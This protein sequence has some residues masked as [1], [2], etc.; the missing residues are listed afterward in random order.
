MPRTSKEI[1]RMKIELVASQLFSQRN[2]NDVTV[3]EIAAAA[4]ITRRTL[5]QHFP[6][7]LTLF[8]SIYEKY[9]KDLFDDLAMVYTQEKSV[10]EIMKDLLVTLFKFSTEHPNFMKKFWMLDTDDPSEELPK[11][12]LQH[13][14]IW[15]RA[16]VDLGVDFYTKNKSQLGLF[17][18][19][20]AELLVHYI[21]GINKGIF[22]QTEKERTLNMDVNNNQLLHIFLEQ[23][24]L[25]FDSI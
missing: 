6:S 23:I 12:V 16:C 21:S 10:K 4:D 9:L 7:K 11:E 25:S 20:D 14:Q 18:K 15:N 19:Y 24:T 22:I 17:E 8:A 2:Y 13:I 1:T 5:Y 3:D